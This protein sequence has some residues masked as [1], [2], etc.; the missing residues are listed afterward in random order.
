MSEQLD[1]LR[2]PTTERR[3]HDMTERERAEAFARLGWFRYT[4]QWRQEQ[5]EPDGGVDDAQKCEATR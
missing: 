4:R 3:L 5:R 2:K 1:L